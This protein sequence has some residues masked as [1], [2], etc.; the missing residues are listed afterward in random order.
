MRYFLKLR[1]DGTSFHGWQKLQGFPTV[2]G[3]IQESLSSIFNR[4]ISIHGCGRTDSG[5]HAQKYYAHLD[6]EE[7]EKSKFIYRLNRMLPSSIEI[8]DLL[9]VLS[10]A[11]AQRDATERTYAYHISTHKD[12][13]TYPFSYWLPYSIDLQALNEISTLLINTRNFTAFTKT[14]DR[15][16]NLDCTVTEAVWLRDH[17]NSVIFRIKADHFLRGMIRLLVGHMLNTFAGKSS[18]DEIKKG[19]NSGLRPPFFHMAPPQ[20]L[21]LVDIKYPYLD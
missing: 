16:K 5:V 21:H 12:P 10:S 15:Q 9:D 20:G 3:L 8:I 1:Y 11:H 7:V 19:L 4:P 17:E 14:P 6:C 2:Q 13:F 18:F